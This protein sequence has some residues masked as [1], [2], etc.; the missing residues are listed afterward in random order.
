MLHYER[1]PNL[2]SKLKWNN[3]F[4]PFLA[5]NPFI[6]W[7]SMVFWQYSTFFFLLKGG[8]CYSIWIFRSDLE[9]SHHFIIINHSH[10]LASR[11][12]PFVK[13]FTFRF[14][15]LPCIYVLSDYVIIFCTLRSQFFVNFFFKSKGTKIRHKLLGLC[16]SYFKQESWHMKLCPNVCVHLEYQSRSLELAWSLPI[17]R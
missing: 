13:I 4:T 12:P 10:H 7:L 2:V 8:K 16:T 1:I 5:K 14:S 3:I 6:N 11:R 17:R 9:Y 15:G